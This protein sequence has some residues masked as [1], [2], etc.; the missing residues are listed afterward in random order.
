MK[1]VKK[2]VCSCMA[3]AMVFS[4]AAI[5][6]F[7]YDNNNNNRKVVSSYRS[8]NVHDS[9]WHVAAIDNSGGTPYYT[10]FREKRDY[11]SSYVKSWSSNQ[12][13]LYCWVSR[14]SNGD[15][16]GDPTDRYYGHET[17]DGASKNQ[18]RVAPGHHAYLK[19]Y[20]KEDGYRYA[21]IG[22]IMQMEGV[23][24]DFYWSPDSV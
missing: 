5:P 24:Y 18:V 11:T 2:F 12:S 7:A 3:F 10:D 22:F 23:D 17:W 8:G 15:F 9:L 4:S 21:G 16:N 19:N 6:A 14:S 13:N 1:K 20:V